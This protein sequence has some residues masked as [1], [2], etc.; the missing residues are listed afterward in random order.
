[1]HGE[2]G[3]QGTCTFHK[4]EFEGPISMGGLASAATP[5]LLGPR[6]P[7]QAGVAPV[8]AKAVAA[9]MTLR[10]TSGFIGQQQV[11]CASYLAGSGRATLLYR[12]LS[13]FP[14][15]RRWLFHGWRCCS[16]G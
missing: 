8:A 6:N 11:T 13:G 1:M 14:G 5:E 7:G 2:D 3:D 4:T 12:V 16:G 15:F 9:R 10:K